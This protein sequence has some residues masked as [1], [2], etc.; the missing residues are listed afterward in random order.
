M[1]DRPLPL[2]LAP[3]GIGDRALCL[4]VKVGQ[5]AYRLAEDALA[6]LDLRIR[7]FSILQGL[8]DVGPMPQVELGR[9]LRMD[10]ATTTAALDHLQAKGAIE[11]ER[12]AADR[13]RYVVGL[14][15]AGRELLAR[16]GRAFDEAEELLAAD[17]GAGAIGDLR[18]LLAGLNESPTVI[19]AFV[20]GHG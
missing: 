14:T 4:L 20:D 1:P 13:R 16:V 8:A 7:H 2:P 12:D 19:E 10:P 11:R 5:V 15:A 18:G 3:G 6:P 9:Y 17:V